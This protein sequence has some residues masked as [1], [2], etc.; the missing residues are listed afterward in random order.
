[1]KHVFKI[2]KKY[3][4]QIVIVLVLLFMQA[5]F[6][7]KLP[8]YTSKIVNVGIQQGGIENSTPEV[9]MESDYNKILVFMSD[10]DKTI[11]NDNYKLISKSNLDESEYKKYLK[12]YPEIK[13][14]NLYVLKNN[15][16]TD[17]IDCTLTIFENVNMTEL[18]R[19]NE[20]NCK[21][22]NIKPVELSKIKQ[23]SLYIELSE[24]IK[25]INEFRNYYLNSP[26]ENIKADIDSELKT[27]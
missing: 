19:I 18:E 2:L 1:M 12:K 16:D 23:D 9:M 4:L 14:Q 10:D 6:D 3:T 20:F 25:N 15:V 11:I 22:L 8:D 5:M 27:E 26:I 24:R 21:I 13:N 7:L 17:T